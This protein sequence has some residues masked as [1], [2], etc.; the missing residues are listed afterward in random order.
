MVH[1]VKANA[2]QA[3]VSTQI[4]HS[5]NK[6]MEAASQTKGCWS[7]LYSHRWGFESE[8]EICGQ[9]EK[10]L[11][12]KKS[13]LFN[14]TN[15]RL[16][17]LSTLLIINVCSLFH[18]LKSFTEKNKQDVW[19]HQLGFI[20]WSFEVDHEIEEVFFFSFSK[21]TILLENV[22]INSFTMVLDTWCD[23]KGAPVL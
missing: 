22:L 2:A 23:Y 6:T 7:T 11:Y 21:R 15:M 10:Y 9:L 12:K 14:P 16:F 4:P 17:H 1:A 18:T 13:P 19:T 5:E 8:H 20:S 3:P